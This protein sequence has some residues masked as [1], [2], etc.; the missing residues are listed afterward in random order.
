MNL[1]KGLKGLK[2]DATRHDTTRSFFSVFFTVQQL[3]VGTQSAKH[4]NNKI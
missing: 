3:H 1:K 2:R 4:K